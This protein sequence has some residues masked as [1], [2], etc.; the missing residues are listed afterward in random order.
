LRTFLYWWEQEVEPEGWSNPIRKAK[1]PKV[2]LE[3]LEP[4]SLVDISTII[5]TCNK[6][7]NGLRYK[8]ILFGLLDT[9]ARADEFLG[10]K[11]DDLNLVTGQIIIREGKGGKF[12]IVFLGKTSL[13]AVRAYLKT[14]TDISNSL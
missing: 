9:G 2:H 14:R 7:F 13:R 8:S 11:L 10:M 5:E 4:V 3:L 12:R 1:P 6:T